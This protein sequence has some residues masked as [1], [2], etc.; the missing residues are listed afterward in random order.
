M[1]VIRDAYLGVCRVGMAHQRC[2]SIPR[3]LVDAQHCS[4]FLRMRAH[5][6][7]R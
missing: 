6:C 4:G 1:S 3:V 7:Y 5:A 2:L